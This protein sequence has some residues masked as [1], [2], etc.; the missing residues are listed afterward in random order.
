VTTEPDFT[1]P[2]AH[3]RVRIDKR[4][5]ETGR[6]TVQ[7]KVRTEETWLREELAREDVQVEWVD[8]DREVD[9]VPQ[10]RTEGNTLVVPLY[11]EVLVVEKRL[12]LRQELHIHRRTSVDVVEEP[13]TV[14]RLEAEVVRD[15][16]DGTST[17]PT[18]DFQ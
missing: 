13:V 18:E 7:T 2:L 4:V 8:I 3:E 1:V 10:V 11:E 6:V 17:P 14:R 15:R 9:E 5:V 16:G 12:V